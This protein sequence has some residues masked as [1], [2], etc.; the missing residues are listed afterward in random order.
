MWY[1]KSYRRHLADMHID[2]WSEEFLS[3]FSPEKYVE[4]LKT[5]KITNA[6]I[7]L[8]SHVGLCYFPTKVGVMHK[9]FTC[10]EDMI[11]RLVDLCHKNGIAV[12]GYYSL[13][14]NTREHDRHTDWRMLTASGKSRRENADEAADSQKLDFA[15]A[16]SGRYGQIGRAHV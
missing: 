16:R 11:K 10:R 2:D 13:I 4:N 6:M 15:S 9:A 1:E 8:Q 5:A 14:Y 3:E 12:S 7:Y